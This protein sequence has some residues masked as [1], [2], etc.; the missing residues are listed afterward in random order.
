MLGNPFVNF[1]PITLLTSV[2][3]EYHYPLIRGMRSHEGKILALRLLN[4]RAW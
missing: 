2:K 3:E 1:L 4:Q